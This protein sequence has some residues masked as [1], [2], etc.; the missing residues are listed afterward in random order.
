MPLEKI[1]RNAVI[2]TL[3]TGTIIYYLFDKGF[4]PGNIFEQYQHA[5]NIPFKTLMGLFFGS[6]A[7]TSQFYKNYK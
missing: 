5:N 3:V 4:E 2:T 6:L 1:T 7:A